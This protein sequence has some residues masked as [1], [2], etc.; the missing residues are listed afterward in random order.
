MKVFS[1]ACVALFLLMMFIR[2]A[3]TEGN[4]PPG[5]YPTTGA[6]DSVQGC[7]PIPSDGVNSAQPEQGAAR[8]WGAIAID[9]SSSNAGIGVSVAA[10]S[11]R[12]ATREAL[13]DCRIKGGKGCKINLSYSNQCAVVIAGIPYSRAHAGPT[14]EIAAASGLRLCEEA[15]ADECQVYYKACSLPQ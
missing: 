5:Y 4:C 10:N 12:Q 8:K 3:A 11:K 13:D 15:G 14:V 7:A 6:Q 9:L 1:R 2:S